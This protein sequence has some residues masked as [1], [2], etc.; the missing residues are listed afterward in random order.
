MWHKARKDN[1]KGITSE[2]YEASVK[3]ALL[4]TSLSDTDTLFRNAVMVAVDCES[5]AEP[6]WENAAYFTV[7]R[8]PEGM[9]AAELRV[10]QELRSVVEKA[11]KTCDVSKP[12]N[13]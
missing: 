4:D 3:A 1:E 6:T 13:E 7:K 5:H 12:M 9:L 8:S 11:L 10:P 2:A